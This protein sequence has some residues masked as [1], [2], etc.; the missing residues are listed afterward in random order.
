MDTFDFL[1]QDNTLILWA[2]RFRLDPENSFVDR[3]KVRFHLEE[4]YDLPSLSIKLY[5]AWRRDKKTQ[6]TT[7]DRCLWLK[8]TS[9]TSNQLVSNSISRPV[10]TSCFPF[11]LS[12]FC[13]TSFFSWTSV[14]DYYI[15]DSDVV[16]IQC[17]NLDFDICGLTEMTLCLPPPITMGGGVVISQHITVAGIQTGNPPTPVFYSQTVE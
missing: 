15:Y 17:T 7:D 16:Q 12:S 2:M 14:V 13:I 4:L 3:F 9:V 6:T 11:F 1:C 10:F 5:R 8:Q